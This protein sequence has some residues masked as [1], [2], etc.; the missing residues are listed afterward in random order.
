MKQSILLVLALA[1]CSGQRALLIKL[2]ALRIGA[3]SSCKVRGQC[4]ASVDCLNAVVAATGSLDGLA[5][6]VKAAETGPCKP[7]APV[8]KP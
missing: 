4:P 3:V 1:G 5:E 6:S 8:S 2:D 7:F